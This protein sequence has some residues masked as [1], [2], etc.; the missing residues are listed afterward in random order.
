MM[1]VQHRLRLFFM[2]S[3]VA[4][5]VLGMPSPRAA[6]SMPHESHGETSAQ[7]QAL[8]QPLWLKGLVTAGGIGLM[9]L[10]LWWFLGHASG[11]PASKRDQV[12]RSEP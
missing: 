6:V 8:E 11:A 7:F 12:S 3:L 2:G 1:T 10:E 9:G 5:S 4:L